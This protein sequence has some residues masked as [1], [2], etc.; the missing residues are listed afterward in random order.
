MVHLED[1]GRSIPDGN[2]VTL[3]YNA[4]SFVYV[5]R[6]FVL[7]SRIRRQKAQDSSALHSSGEGKDGFARNNTQDLRQGHKYKMW[8]EDLTRVKA[9]VGTPKYPFF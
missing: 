5:S 4:A 3:A 8:M 2:P 1:Q 6:A 7:Y 9:F